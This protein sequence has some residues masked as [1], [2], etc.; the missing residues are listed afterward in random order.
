M[1][2]EIRVGTL[3]RSFKTLITK[4][5]AL[6]KPIK[7]L[8]DLR[9]LRRR[10]CYRHE[11]L[12]DLEE[13]VCERDGFCAAMPDAGASFRAFRTYMSIEK[14]AGTLSRSFKTLIKKTRGISKSIKDLKDLSVLR[15]RTCYRHEGLPDLE[16]T[17]CE[18]DGFCAAM[19][20]AG[21]SFR[22]FRTYM[23]IEKRV[24]PFSRSIRTLIKNA[25]HGKTY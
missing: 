9:L 5:A 16:E 17:V 7:D 24:V 23:S 4:R 11:G 18:R 6:T 22:A 13:T 25:P 10:T 19:P 1:S 14:R 3:S 20:D 15:R 2:I 21:A 12:P 8:K